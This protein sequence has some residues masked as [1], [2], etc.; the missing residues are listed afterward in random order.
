MPEIKTIPVGTRIGRWTI[1]SDAGQ[2]KGKSRSWCR[3]QCGTEMLI[4]NSGLRNDRSLSCGCISRE[5]FQKII[6]KHGLRG[7]G[8]MMPEY[9]CWKSMMA[10]CYGKNRK[11]YP[12]YGGRGIKVC[13]RWFKFENFL[14]DMGKR[15]PGKFSIGR[16]NNNGNYE[17]ENCQW[18]TQKQQTGNT[19]RSRVFTF[20]G[21]TGCIKHLAEHFGIK[22]GTCVAR[23]NAGLS[24]KDIFTMKLMPGIPFKKRLTAYSLKA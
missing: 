1:I 8:K 21:I 13:N 6:T 18:E 23:A 3:C 5:R 10:R 4:V 24:A 15:P 12:R 11:D 22:Y 16:K 7:S 19:C 9:Q 2:I 17:P 20:N 14:K